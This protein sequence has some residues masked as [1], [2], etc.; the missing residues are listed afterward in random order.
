MS[1]QFGRWQFDD[2]PVA[3]EYLD[4]VCRLLAP[5]ATNDRRTYSEANLTILYFPFHTTSES[6]GETQP[7]L[8]DLG[9][10]CTWDG[11]LDNR[12]ALIRELTAN[13]R[14]DDTDVSVVAAAYDRWGTA[15]FPKFIGDWAM[16]VWDPT[17]HSL[18]LAKD[19]LGSR[20]LYYCH[21]SAEITWS[22]VLEPLVLLRE[23]PLGLCD[24]YL[25]GWLSFFPAANLTPFH[26]ISAVPPSSFVRLSRTK[27]TVN[28]YWDFN[29]DANI[30]YRT[31][32]EYEEHFRTL[33]AASVRRRL[34]SDSPV[35][36]ELS[37]GL[38]SSSIVCVADE[39]IAH[40]SA[41]LPRLDTISYY[42]D[43]E[44]NWNEK[45]FFTK[46]EERRGRSGC[47]IEVVP[48][49]RFVFESCGAPATTPASVHS[50][51]A[52][53][54]QFKAHL[55]SGRY[56]AILSGIGGD[57]VTGGV[58]SP[59]PELCDLF[60]RAQWTTLARQLKAWA[61]FQR[62]P[63]A[64]LLVDAIGAFLPRLLAASSKRGRK[65]P[66]LTSS[67]L[68]RHR[69]ALEGYET[70]LNLTGPLPSLQ[71]N[72]FTLEFLRRQ[73]ACTPPCREPLY[74]AR[75]PYLD[76]ELLEFLYAIPRTQLVRPGERRSLM[77]RA[78]RGIV[79]PEILDRK[80]K[81]FVMRG[82]SM[83]LQS[84]E[85]ILGDLQRNMISASL[86][87]VS[88]PRLA[89]AIA[90]T[91]LGQEIDLI[92]VARTFALEVW[93]RRASNGTRPILSLTR[94]PQM[95]ALHTERAAQEPS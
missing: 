93:L 52:A 5:Y 71:E 37:G 67:F 14:V 83:A 43:S 18:I 16:V 38:D 49:D 80:R 21:N 28:K 29:P 69:K 90:S 85:A 95:L 10:V 11:R 27:V 22:S 59:L 47:H 73:L 72:L 44:P 48:Q 33:F 13:S 84:D 6:R 46:V 51:N 19:F 66:W 1:A 7:Y 89:D 3:A 82:P 81:A 40:N 9:R 30:Q 78:L 62:R 32:A 64:H 8:S 74:E 26:G 92:A 45:P 36:A 57:E 79:P 88:P 39:L 17:D 20:H 61:L 75:Y 94:K 70:R 42:N 68:R 60:A 54:E 91:R 23:K 12:D 65:A 55:L 56:R 50:S 63:W 24:E 77:R 31:D 15:S 53:S 87:I 86:T 4:K 58:P 76:R 2:R 34:R 25:A 41:D 35:L